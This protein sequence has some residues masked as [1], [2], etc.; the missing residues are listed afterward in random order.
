MGEKRRHYNYAPEFDIL[1]REDPDA[2]D[3]VYQLAIWLNRKRRHEQTECIHAR[4]G[5][6]KDNAKDVGTTLF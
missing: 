6:G 4:L 3:T 1:A 2:F 5:L